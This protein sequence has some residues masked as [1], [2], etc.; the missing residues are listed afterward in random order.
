MLLTNVNIPIWYIGLHYIFAP[1]ESNSTFTYY[2]CSISHDIPLDIP[3]ELPVLPSHD[4]PSTVGVSQSE[5]QHG[6][7]EGEIFSPPETM[8]DNASDEVHLPSPIL[9]PQRET[10]D[11]PNLNT[12]PP[13]NTAEKTGTPWSMHESPL[14]SHQ[15][16]QLEGPSSPPT[17]APLV[18]GSF[19]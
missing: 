12:S 7:V 6:G 1:C 8:R 3:H 2:D 18:S 10:L 9:R 13:K 19:G 14:H 4:I 15:P 16:L 5:E 11:D 17:E